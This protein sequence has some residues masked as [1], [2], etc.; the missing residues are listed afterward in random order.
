MTGEWLG[1]TEALAEL[2]GYLNLTEDVALLKKRQ[3]SMA[4]KVQNTLWS[5]ASQ[6][7]LNY[8]VDTQTFNT[9]TSPTSF[10][11]MLS[12][13]ATVEQALMMTRRWLTNHSGYCLGNHSAP[14][15]PPSPTTPDAGRSLTNWW[16]AANSDNAICI[17]GGP[18]CSS[19]SAPL[20]TQGMDAK[21][22]SAAHSGDCCPSSVYHQDG[23]APRDYGTYQ[24]I[25]TEAQGSY[26]LPSHDELRALGPTHG[27]VDLKMFYSASNKD[28]FLGTN[29]TFEG[30]N[31]TGYVEVLAQSLDGTTNLSSVA[32]TIFKTPPNASYVPMGLYWSDVRKDV[33]N[34]ATEAAHHWLGND[35]V[36]IQRLGYVMPGIDAAQTGGLSPCRY[37]LPSTPNDDPACEFI[38]HSLQSEIDSEL[39]VLTTVTLQIRTI[40]TGAA[41]C[42]QG[43]SACVLL[44]CVLASHPSVAADGALSISWFT[45]VFATQNMLMSQRFKPHA[46]SSQSRAARP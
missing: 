1:E 18:H 35:Y 31:P 30:I 43:A 22:R 28:N 42:K 45:W 5:A 44:K 17:R 13:T 10:Y 41:A 36:H 20:D 15:S 34:V 29:A 39:G 19:A 37:S 7:Y 33:Q 6:I 46:S 11:P 27:T 40:R 23:L 16:S 4:S 26:L 24:F 38:A 3:A 32:A 2:A 9:H 25:R 21:H 8:Q 14:P 12:G